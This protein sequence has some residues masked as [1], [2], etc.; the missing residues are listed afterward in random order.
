MERGSRAFFRFITKSHLVTNLFWQDVQRHHRPT[1]LS[2]R[3]ETRELSCRRLRLK[4]NKTCKQYTPIVD[5]LEVLNSLRASPG[6]LFAHSVCWNDLFDW[7]FDRAIHEPESDKWM[8]HQ[9]WSI[10]DRWAMW[11]V[12]HR[13]ASYRNYADIWMGAGPACVTPAIRQPNASLPVAFVPIRQH[14]RIALDRR[15]SFDLDHYRCGSRDL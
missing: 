6:S 13:V 8:N 5:D 1:K 15:R 10:V 4:C 14:F 7:P 2:E 3:E 12:E 11:L 9:K